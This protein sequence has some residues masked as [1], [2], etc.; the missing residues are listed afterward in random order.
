MKA[1]KRVGIFAVVGAANTL[2]DYI[3]FMVFT[4]FLAN[5]ISSIIAAT[6]TTVIAFFLHR[7]FTWRD[8]KASRSS[9]IK[10]LTINAAVFWGVRTFVVWVLTA[11]S[12]SWLEPLFGFAG[13]VLRFLPYDF[14]VRTGIFGITTL[15]TLTLTY[16]LYNKFVFPRE[17]EIIDDKKP[18]HDSKTD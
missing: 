3:L 2:F 9:M 7:G 5:E 18:R 1:Q 10:F 17:I 4:T 14:V 13:W 12:T 8:R 6:I 16:F 15:I 11:A